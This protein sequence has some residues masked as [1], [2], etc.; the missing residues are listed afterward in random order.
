MLQVFVGKRHGKKH[1]KQTMG[2][3]WFGVQSSYGSKKMLGRP[4]T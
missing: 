1:E 3:L 2:K 4:M